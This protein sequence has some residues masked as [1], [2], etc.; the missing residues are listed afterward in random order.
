MNKITK[1]AV[2]CL[3]TLAVSAPIVTAPKPIEAAAKKS[4]VKQ[5]YTPAE[6]AYIK[7]QSNVL[8]KL[9]IQ[10][11][12]FI[13]FMEQADKYEDEEFAAIVM[14]KLD[15]WNETLK[16][17]AKYRPQDVP[18]KFKKVQSLFVQATNYNTS[19]YQIIH[20][21]FLGDKELSDAEMD[22]KME[23][24]V[25]QH[26]SFIGKASTFDQEIKRLNKLYQ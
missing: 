14:S 5:S 24:F 11:E 20:S 17:A 21:A 8:Y 22:S 23:K 6:R 9:R 4:T 10:T 2:S 26:F 19:A 1:V 25:K 12:D 3:L 13:N 7:H 16:Q 18:G 15:G